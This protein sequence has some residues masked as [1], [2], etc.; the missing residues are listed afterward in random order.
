MR[1]TGCIVL[2]FVVKVTDD[3]G[4]CDALICCNATGVAAKPHSIDGVAFFRDSYDFAATTAQE[5]DLCA[6]YRTRCVAARYPGSQ[7]EAYRQ[8]FR[9]CPEA[10]WRPRP[11]APV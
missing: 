2:S 11:R 7:W 5:L 6:P 10:R 8:G 4:R 9:L 3:T 1:D